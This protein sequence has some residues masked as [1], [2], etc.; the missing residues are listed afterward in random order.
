MDFKIR[1]NGLSSMQ[2]ANRVGSLP[3]PHP[4]LA[5]FILSDN[6]PMRQMRQKLLQIRHFAQKIGALREG[7][8][9]LGI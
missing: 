6:L 4:A 5:D 7:W 1:N 9:S 8:F 2:I 3:R